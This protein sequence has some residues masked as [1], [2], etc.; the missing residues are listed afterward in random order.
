MRDLISFREL[1][2][3]TNKIVLKDSNTTFIHSHSNIFTLPQSTVY[4]YNQACLIFAT[5]PRISQRT[6]HIAIPYHFFRT[7]V[8]ELKIKVI[9]IGTDNQ[10]AGPFTKRLPV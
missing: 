10:L 3:E 7:K 6:K 5:M 1:L 8:R 9:A 4:E 2:K